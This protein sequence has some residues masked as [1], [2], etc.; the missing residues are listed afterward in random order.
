VKKEIMKNTLQIISDTCFH[1]ACSSYPRASQ[2]QNFHT[3]QYLMYKDHSLPT[4]FTNK[5]ISL[6]FEGCHSG[7]AEDSDQLGCDAVVP[8]KQLSCFER[9]QDLYLQGS[10]R[11]A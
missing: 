4:V 10:S 5:D 6:R 1:T 7:A 2:P 11:T 3:L 8:D 9:S